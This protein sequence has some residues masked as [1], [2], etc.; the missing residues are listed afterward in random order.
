M[1]PVERNSSK[2]RFSGSFLA[3]LYLTLA[4][5]I[6]CTDEEEM[7]LMAAIV[8]TGR[9]LIESFNTESWIPLAI[10]QLN[11]TKGV[12]AIVER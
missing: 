11:W 8:F 7:P 6:R 10:E 2:Q 9:L 3:G 4:V 5:K 1:F 12:V